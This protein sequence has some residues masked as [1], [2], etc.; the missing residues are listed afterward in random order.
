[1]QP[2]RILIAVI[3]VVFFT[4][5]CKKALEEHP[6]DFYSSENMFNTAADAEAAATGMYGELHTWN[7]FKSP[8]WSDIDFD[9]DHVSGPGWLM[10]TEGVANYSSAWTVPSLW[11]GFYTL[12]YQAT[13]ILDK[14]PAIQMDSIVRGRILGEAHFFRAW[15]FFH[16]VRLWGDVPLRLN[17][18]TGAGSADM[19][20]APVKD[21]YAQIISDLQQAESL[22]LAKKDPR[23]GPAGKVTRGA[24]QTLLAKVYLTMASASLPGAAISVRG[25]TDNSDYTWTKN[26][27]KGYEG[28]DSKSL[29]T[30]ARDKAKQVMDSGEYKLFNSWAE[31]WSIGN[32]NGQEHI[33]SLQA[34]N[35][36]TFGTLFE[37]YYSAPSF[38]GYG[39]LWITNFHY[40]EYESTD[41]RVLTGVSHRWMQSGAW[42]YYPERDSLKYKYGT[43]SS[44]ARYMK[45]PFLTKYWTGNMAPNESIG[46]RACN[47][48]LLRYAD[49]L[50]IYAEAENEV[51]G[52][53]LNAYNAI[54][55]I[56]SRSKATPVPPGL[57]QQAFRSFVFA[58][59]GREFTQEANRKFDLL[60]WGIYVQVMSKLGVV[61]NNSKIRSDKQL[62]M[63]IP[64]AELNANKLINGNNPGW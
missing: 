43:D 23:S 29:F 6:Y 19:A 40:D 25:G 27:V 32:K 16:L 14:V 31:V 28:M 9:N 33:W 4:A 53:T 1:M 21:I 41:E 60:R 10:G 24:A 55:Q 61:D 49:V 3:T 38:G 47:F 36:N 50:L 8:Y 22:L 37:Q 48:P 15:A 52:P 58:E 2:I 51:N 59:R 26:V 63:P 18:L 57:T 39:Y 30:K 12:N 54:N 45:T 35:D 13:T 44:V 56:R 42:M 5:G 64:D 11:L 20:R 34:T 46:Y 7:M 62:L 17:R